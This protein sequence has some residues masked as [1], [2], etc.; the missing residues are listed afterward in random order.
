LI[1]REGF[2]R[3]RTEREHKEVENMVC[4]MM[5]EEKQCKAFKRRWGKVKERR[6]EGRKDEERRRR[7][8][9][10]AGR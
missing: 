9:S 3:A 5:G 8:L 4:Y 6:E 7:L 1:E 10:P 2:K